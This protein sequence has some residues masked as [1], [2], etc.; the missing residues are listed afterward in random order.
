MTK[1]NI[2]TLF[3]FA[4]LSNL[5]TFCYLF[6][7]TSGIPVIQSWSLQMA[8]IILLNNTVG[9]FCNAD[10]CNPKN[11]VKISTLFR[12]IWYYLFLFI[13]VLHLKFFKEKQLWIFYHDDSMHNHS[14]QG[15]CHI[16]F[17][18]FSV[19]IPWHAWNFQLNY[20]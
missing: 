3:I 11:C 1:E 8:L 7:D 17:C 20:V 5:I 18:F 19:I 14:S 4:C 10:L 15:V 2:L 9:D 13:L 12:K 16:N 6:A